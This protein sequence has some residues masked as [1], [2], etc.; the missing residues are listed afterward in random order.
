M[1]IDDSL[2]IRK[3]LSVSLRRAGYEVIDF[4]DGVEALCWLA[5]PDAII[6]VLVL[7]DLGLPK[8]D[9][10]HVIRH[11]KAR[12]GLEQT[13]IVILLK[14]DGLLD[15]VKGRLAGAH[16]Y[17]TRPFR[18]QTIVAVVQMHLGAADGCETT[19]Q[20][21]SNQPPALA[22]ALA[23]SNQLAQRGTRP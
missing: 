10:Y 8:L 19:E 18:A 6:P 3:M 21:S 11:L 20:S 14:R 22:Q 2:T 17:I 15:R 4:P 5:A 23:G 9:G 7:V 16:A 1:V 12:P 13:V